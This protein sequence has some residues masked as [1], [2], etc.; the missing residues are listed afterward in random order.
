VPQVLPQV[1]FVRDKMDTSV[2]EERDCPFSVREMLGSADPTNNGVGGRSADAINYN[3]SPRE[4]TLLSSLRS[5]A[6]NSHATKIDTFT[7]VKASANMG[8]MSDISRVPPGS[9]PRKPQ[10]NG[11]RSL[12]VFQR[13][14]PSRVGW[15][16]RRVVSDLTLCRQRHW[17]VLRRSQV[18]NYTA[19]SDRLVHSLTASASAVGTSL[20][21]LTGC[22]VLAL[23]S[24]SP[25]MSA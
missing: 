21:V 10:A 23:T 3:I 20:Q 9:Q 1:P 18:L 12:Q 19:F 25:S 15:P 11:R 14:R 7:L 16:A 22:Q 2:T 13:Y 4:C 6:T 17:L 5:E 8:D 24:A